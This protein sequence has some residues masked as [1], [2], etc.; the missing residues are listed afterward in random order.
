MRYTAAGWRVKA[1]GML[2]IASGKRVAYSRGGG[3]GGRACRIGS[4]T[5]ES[6]KGSRTGR[7]NK[8]S[9]HYRRLATRYTL[10]KPRKQMSAKTKLK[11]WEAVRRSLGPMHSSP[12]VLYVWPA[13]NETLKNFAG[14]DYLVES[15]YPMQPLLQPGCRLRCRSSSYFVDDSTM[16]RSALNNNCCNNNRNLPFE[17][18]NGE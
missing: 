5:G 16:G 13:I 9:S 1:R 8:L 12:R 18:I 3:G 2:G 15:P 10:V 7:V 11:R 17:N 6:G 4:R 14:E